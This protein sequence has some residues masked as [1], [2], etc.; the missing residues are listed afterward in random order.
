[1]MES[2]ESFCLNKRNFNETSSNIIRSLLADE[3]FT[4][5]ILACSDNTQVRA[6][7]AVL[8]ATSKFFNNILKMNKGPNLVLYLKGVKQ[9]DLMSLMEF[10]YC[11]KTNVKKAG[12]SSFLEAAEELRIEGLVPSKP[13][14]VQET[15]QEILGLN[16]STDTEQSLYSFQQISEPS[17]LTNISEDITEVSN[18]TDDDT[19]A[20]TITE[21]DEIS[22]ITE[23]DEISTVTELS[24]DE[25]DTVPPSLLNS[26]SSG[27]ELTFSSPGFCSTML[28]TPAQKPQHKCTECGRTFTAAYSV[29]RHMET[30]HKVEG[31]RTEVKQEVE[32]A[33]SRF[34]CHA[35]LCDFSTLHKTSLKRHLLLVH[36]IETPPKPESSAEKKYVCN[37]CQFRTSHET[38]LKRHIKGLHE[39]S[40]S[41]QPLSL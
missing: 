28:T 25:M 14:K 31:I 24:I 41:V 16:T 5:V 21:A 18:V 20:S 13:E 23:V 34:P 35:P 12:L 38:S 22:T 17:S 6:H 15:R 30:V 3:D 33:P 32:E 9:Q 40:G 26:V 27:E 39:K 10:I 19:G 36:K 7:R 37:Q 11:G 8:S 1:M 4:D 29:R 2:D